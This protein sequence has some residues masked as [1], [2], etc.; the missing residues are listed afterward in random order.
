MSTMVT[1]IRALSIYS[2]MFM[3]AQS[4]SRCKHYLTAAYGI[5]SHHF[6]LPGNLLW[7]YIQAILGQRYIPNIRQDACIYAP[8]Y[9]LGIYQTMQL[10]TLEK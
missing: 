9:K 5:T 1:A 7:F 3:I 10:K 2:P 8:V 4:K 6:Y